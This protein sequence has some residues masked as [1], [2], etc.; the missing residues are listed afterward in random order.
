MRRWFL[1]FEV[2]ETNILE[3]PWRKD[4]L[5]L[6][7]LVDSDRDYPGSKARPQ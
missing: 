1:F 7:T 2:I 3:E 5:L 4:A 6:R